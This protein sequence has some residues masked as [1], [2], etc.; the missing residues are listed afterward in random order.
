MPK[1]PR[2]HELESL[3][4]NILCNLFIQ[5]GWV[6]EDLQHDYGED[7]LVRIFEQGLATHLSFFVQAKA[8]DHI[9]K[10]MRK[11]GKSLTYPIKLTHVKHWNKF[12]EPVILTIWDA[13]SNTTY[14]E[15]I[16]EKVVINK[17]QE[18]NICIDIPTDNIVD[19]EGL[20]RILARTKA[21]FA[22]FEREREGA[23]VLIEMLEAELNVEIEYD[24][25]FGL[26]MVKWPDGTKQ[27]TLFGKAAVMV[28]R[29]E[30]YYG[31]SG[32]DTL[33]QILKIAVDNLE[34][35]L[36]LHVSTEDYKRII[37]RNAEIDES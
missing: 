27:C 21:R 6:V 5:V 14:W 3:S 9:D 23:Q 33:S 10:Y 20:K 36:P 24:S 17:R 8:T 16:Q 4:R 35:E 34:R 12:W 30:E 28:D 26:L 37:E 13:K 22:R 15:S 11:D 7:L 19:D 1:R 18:K 2:S 25:Q 29:I 32:P 31:T